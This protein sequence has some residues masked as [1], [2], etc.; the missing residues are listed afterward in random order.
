MTTLLDAPPDRPSAPPRPARRPLLLAGAAGLAVLLL[1]A[2]LLQS[3]GSS[4]DPAASSAESAAGSAEPAVAPGQP[5][6]AVGKDDE[7]VPGASSSLG[8][9]VKTGSIALVARDGGTSALLDAEG[10]AVVQGSAFGLSP[11]FRISYATSE[12][13]LEEACRRI[14]RF[15]ASL[16]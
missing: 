5:D 14:Q 1:L 2:A 13:V 4:T 9:V 15:C 6:R 16:V 3:Q 8:R 7:T 12:D 11:Y 10:V